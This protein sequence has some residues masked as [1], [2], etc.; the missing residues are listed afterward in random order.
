MKFK[1]LLI[2]ILLF[3][4]YLLAQENEQAKKHEDVEWYWIIY[5]KFKID[6]KAEAHDIIKTYWRPIETRIGTEQYAYEFETG[7]WDLLRVVKMPEGISTLEWELS[8]MRIE[9][10]KEFMKIAG[11]EEVMNEVR[12]KWS[13]CLQDIK[14]DIAKTFI[15]D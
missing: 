1:I 10:N 2:A 3:P 12:K 13:E 11:S 14:T 5:L 8:P 6:K 9:Y 7:E 4:C 15:P